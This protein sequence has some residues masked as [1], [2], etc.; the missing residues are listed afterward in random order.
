MM[1]KIP[2]RI[3]DVEKIPQVSEDIKSMLRSNS[4]V[5]LE[6]EAPYCFLSRIETSHAE[7]TIGCNLKHMVSFLNFAF[8]HL[9]SQEFFCLTF[10]IEMSIELAPLI[11]FPLLCLNYSFKRKCLFTR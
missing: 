4:K 10:T 11:Q 9:K 5:F 7:L 3:G 2:V 6:K 1:T 8:R